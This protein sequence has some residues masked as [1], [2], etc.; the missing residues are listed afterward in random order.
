M[1]DYHSSYK[2]FHLLPSLFYSC[3]FVPDWNYGSIVAI[4]PYLGAQY[5]QYSYIKQPFQATHLLHGLL[6]VRVIR[7]ECFLQLLPFTLLSQLLS[8]L[9]DFNHL[10]TGRVQIKEA[11]CFPPSQFSPEL[12]R[13]M[14]RNKTFDRY[15]CIFYRHQ[16]TGCGEM[17]LDYRATCLFFKRYK[18]IYILL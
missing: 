10:H 14:V 6:K 13:T 18:Y 2:Y 12:P 8:I 5:V 3:I 17:N 4:H 9:N 11:V 15:V 7:W 16:P 1:H